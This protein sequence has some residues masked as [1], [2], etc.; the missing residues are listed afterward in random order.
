MTQADD[1][2][3]IRSDI[4]DMRTEARDNAKS[5]SMQH[6]EIFSILREE[7]N[8]HAHTKETVARHDEQLHTLRDDV[9]SIQKKQSTQALR[10]AWGKGVWAVVIAVSSLIAWG[11][12]AAISVLK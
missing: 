2:K 4:R 11:I 5:N 6:G 7:A 3:A 12:G 1:I 10:H 9:K 8:A